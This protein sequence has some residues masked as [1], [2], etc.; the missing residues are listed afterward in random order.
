M[1]ALEEQD[2]LIASGTDTERVGGA[3][4]GANACCAVQVA[5]KPTAPVGDTQL[6][7]IGEGLL[8]REERFDSLA[9]IASVL[10]MAGGSGGQ[11][12][13]SS[14]KHFRLIG[15]H[16]PVGVARYQRCQLPAKLVG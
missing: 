5:G 10:S 15:V 16:T 9:E 3:I 11:N 14:R 6:T 2:L 7:G 1:E 4:S 13:L 12:A 8:A